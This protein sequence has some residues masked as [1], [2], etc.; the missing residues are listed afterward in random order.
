MLALR[1]RGLSECNDGYSKK[2]ATKKLKVAQIR[3]IAKTLKLE[4]GTHLK[5]DR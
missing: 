4:N 5:D 2:K 3:S 1:K